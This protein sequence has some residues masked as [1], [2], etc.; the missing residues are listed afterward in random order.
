MQVM[1]CR[2]KLH[3]KT[4]RAVEKG[5]KII[6]LPN[7]NQSSY[8]KPDIMDNQDKPGGALAK[9]SGTDIANASDG[10]RFTIGEL[11]GLADARRELSGLISLIISVPAGRPLI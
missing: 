2:T 9:A 11:R 1:F 8:M 7:I 5:K 10:C 4:Q 3:K 6:T